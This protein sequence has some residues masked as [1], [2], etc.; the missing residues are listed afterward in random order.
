MVVASNGPPSRAVDGDGVVWGMDKPLTRASRLGIDPDDTVAV[1]GDKVLTD[2]LLSHRWGADFYLK[3]FTAR[4]AGRGPR[5]LRAL[6]WA[7]RRLLFA[8]ERLD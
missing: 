8:V 5:P 7:A 4:D 6:E 2:G 1:V 3:P